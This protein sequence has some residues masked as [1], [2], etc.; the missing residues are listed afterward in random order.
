[1]QPATTR[2][3]CWG[4]LASCVLA[5]PSIR[6]VGG[7]RSLLLGKTVVSPVALCCVAQFVSWVG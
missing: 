2:G 1:M 6:Q 3:L 4:L 5:N 7:T